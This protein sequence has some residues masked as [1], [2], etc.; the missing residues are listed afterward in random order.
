M[1]TA[2]FEGGQAL[3]SSKQTAGL[4]ETRLIEGPQVP[5]LTPAHV[6][7]NCVGKAMPGAS[8][9]SGWYRPRRLLSHS[10]RLPS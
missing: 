1:G 2:R 3:M 7:A 8:F 9:N 5:A 4:T 10:E 6:E